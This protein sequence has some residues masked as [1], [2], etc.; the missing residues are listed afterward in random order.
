MRG[1]F[2]VILGWLVFAGLTLSIVV[3]HGS[4]GRDNHS[5]STDNVFAELCAELEE[6]S[7]EAGSKLVSVC[8]AAPLVSIRSDG[9][10]GWLWSLRN[11]GFI[12]QVS[13]GPH[14]LRGPPVPATESV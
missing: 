5:V 6:E 8:K 3:Q 14:Y 2:V 4:S 10:V 11:C 13:S 12:P 7:S 9:P 1:G